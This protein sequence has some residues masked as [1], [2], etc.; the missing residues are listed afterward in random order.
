MTWFAFKGLNNG[1]A[2]NLAGTQEKQAALE[3]FHGYATQAEAQAQPNSVNV[4]TR[5]QADAFIT[6]YNYAVKA[7]EQPGGPNADILNPVNDV[8]GTAQAA[9]NLSG[10]TSMLQLAKD[11]YNVLDSKSTWLRVTKVVV[12]SVMIIIGLVKLTGTDKAVTDVAAKGIG[13]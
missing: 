13:V 2:I 6:D 7:G 8:K 5:L 11:A 12:G 3:G 10:V 4:L 1:K 9:E